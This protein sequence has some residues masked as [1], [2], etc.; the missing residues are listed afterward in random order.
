[1]YSAF[2]PATAG[3]VLHARDEQHLRHR[4]P[5]LPGA[6]ERPLLLVRAETAAHAGS[7]DDGDT[8]TR[9]DLVHRVVVAGPTADDGGGHGSCRLLGHRHDIAR[10]KATAPLRLDPSPR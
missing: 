9:T 8:R 7:H 6:F 10:A 4:Y 3:L 5:G 2:V 1:M